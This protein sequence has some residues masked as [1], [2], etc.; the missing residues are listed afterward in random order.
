VRGAAQG[1]K[2]TKGG[3]S[4]AGRENNAKKEFNKRRDGKTRS[5]KGKKKRRKEKKNTVLGKSIKISKAEWKG[6]GGPGQGLVP[7][8]ELGRP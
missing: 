3:L 5:T 1:K 7:L 4:P 6:K 2:H 8:W